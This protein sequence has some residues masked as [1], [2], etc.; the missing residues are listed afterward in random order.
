MQPQIRVTNK[1]ME[2]TEAGFETDVIIPDVVK[3]VPNPKPIF[4]YCQII[5]PT[6]V[7]PLIINHWFKH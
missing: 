4:I 2:S 6:L 5:R 7:K 1:D 3:I